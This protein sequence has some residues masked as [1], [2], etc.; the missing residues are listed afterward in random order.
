M[1][2]RMV[3][4]HWGSILGGEAPSDQKGEILVGP[5]LSEDQIRRA[6]EGKWGKH[7]VPTHLPELF[8]H[9]GH[10]FFVLTP[11]EGKKALGP[12]PLPK[13][14]WEQWWG[15]GWKSDEDAWEM[16]SGD[17]ELKFTVAEIP[18]LAFLFEP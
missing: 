15:W 3:L 9:P 1:Y 7:I 13:D 16:R 8:V 4:N 2:T 12:M 14:Y 6:K 17:S 10:V 11:E 18:I 5:G